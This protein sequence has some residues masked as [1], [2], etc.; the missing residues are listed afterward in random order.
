MNPRD[1]VEAVGAAFADAPQPD[2]FPGGLGLRWEG[3]AVEAGCWATSDG[4]F[5]FFNQGERAVEA[6]DEAVA[7]LQQIFADQLVL[8]GATARGQL[9]YSLEPA[10]G[11]FAALS[12]LDPAVWSG[13]DIVWIASWNGTRDNTVIPSGDEPRIPR[14]LS[15]SLWASMKG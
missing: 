10:D 14:T 15:D 3:E 9:H 2:E 6:T 4:A 5:V 13:V 7:L 8:V 1:F 11:P 12:Q